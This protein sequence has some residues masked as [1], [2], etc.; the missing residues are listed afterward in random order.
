MIKEYNNGDTFIKENDNYLSENKYLTQFF[1]LDAKL[2]K[3]INKNNYAIKI[4]EDNKKLLAL[5]VSDFA[6][7]LY[8]NPQL[9]SSLLRYIKNKDYYFEKIMTSSVI[10]DELFK[11][12][13]EVLNERYFEFLA[14]DFM[15]ARDYTE[16]SSKDV[17]HA[18]IEDVDEI[19]EMLVKF[20]KD[21]NLDD[22]AN[23]ESIKKNIDKYRII[24]KDGKIVSMAIFNKSINSYHITEVYTR[25]EYRNFG[26]A[27]KI[28]NTIKNEILDMNEVATLNVDKKNPISNHLYASLGFKKLFSQGVY[29]IIKDEK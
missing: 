1:Y 28:V 19:Y 23:I 5:K 18:K 9:L 7:M 22:E 6:L 25:D 8:G 29:H 12:S 20:I 21:C 3:E 14:M 27:R 4:E 26:Y 13:K 10:A 2:L 17:M 16:V 15:E 11:I 24:K